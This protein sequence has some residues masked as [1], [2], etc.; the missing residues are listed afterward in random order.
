MLYYIKAGGP[1]LVVLM[2]LSVISLATIS[3]RA[4]CFYRNKLNFNDSFKKGLKKLLEK[5][6]YDEAISFSRREKGVA[7]KII[8][9]FLVRYCVEGDYKDTDEL[10]RE[11]E[12]EEMESLEKNT[13]I[14]GI[15][16]YTSPMIGLLGTV[17]GMIQA[18]N[19]MAEHGA[20]DPNV[21][22]GGI[23]Q[24]LLTTALGLIIAI[25]SIVAYNMY[26]K[27][28]EK[29]NN[30]VEKIVTSIINTVKR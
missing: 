10:L 8:T 29:T 25:P 4:I 5:K 17:T 30:E 22:A 28:I 7:G 18:F 26:S 16:A 19:K 2:I 9:K 27:R 20:G 12:I 14:L 11:I 1:V 15:I 24:A 23:S 6:D 13:H 21:V 3:E